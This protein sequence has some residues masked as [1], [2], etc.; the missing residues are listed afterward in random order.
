MEY[1]APEEIR[2]NKENVKERFGRQL[3]Q[4][5]LALKGRCVDIFEKAISGKSATVLD[6]GTGHGAFLRAIYGNGYNNI[7]AGD[8]DDYVDGS[9]RPLLKDFKAFDASFE[10]FPWSDKTFDVVTAWEVFE[11][12]ENPHN[13]IR[14]VH[15][16]L[17]GVAS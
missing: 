2:K 4:R 13:A 14:E 12:L 15:R 17:G 6:F 10:K 9:I 5:P 3:D 11:H 8:I 7:Y 16:I 1:L